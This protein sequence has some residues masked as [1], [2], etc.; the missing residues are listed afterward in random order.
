[1]KM[2]IKKSTKYF[3]K[4]TCV[5]IYFYEILETLLSRHDIESL[6]R[7]VLYIYI[8]FITLGLPKNSMTKLT[9]LTLEQAN[10]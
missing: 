9:N 1:M 6:I 3:L 4:W 2:N 5:F 7:D 8:I 10:K